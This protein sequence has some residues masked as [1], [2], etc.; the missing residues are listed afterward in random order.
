MVETKG[1]MRFS[2]KALADDG[3][4]N[5]KAFEGDLS[6]YSNIDLGGDVCE[7]GCFDNDITIS[8]THRPLLWQHD[9]RDVIG[10]F[11]VVSTEGTLRVKGE[12]DLG[13]M[14]GPTAYT[15]LKHGDISG[16][17]IGYDVRDYRYDENGV[18]H[19]LDVVLMEGSVVTFP[20][21]LEARVDGVKQRRLKMSRYERC[22]FLSK[23]TDE[24]RAAALA[25]LDAMDSE[26][27]KEEP[28][29]TEEPAPEPDPETEEPKE[30]TPEEAPEDENPDD[31]KEDGDDATDD[32]RALK[33]SIDKLLSKLEA[34]A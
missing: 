8:G 1:T 21:N 20:M 30:D 17:S 12:I 2:I 9:A 3:E 7:P 16:M 28:E 19:L 32:I 10:S 14:Y 11:D 27:E 22:K 34:P 24:E 6:T 25:E 26:A 29:T 23:M 31:A 5:R 13:T 18:R 15:A 33:E 4:G